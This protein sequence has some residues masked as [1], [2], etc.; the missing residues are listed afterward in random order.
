MKKFLF[1]AVAVA[2]MA[3]CSSN[4]DLSEGQGQSGGKET[5]G[6]QVLN[7]NSITR[8]T[9]LNESGHYNFGV[10]A[11]K[12][13][14]G[15]NSVMDNYLV[16]YMDEVNKKGYYMDGNQTTKGDSEGDYNG[17]SMWQYEML[18]YAEYNYLGTEGYYTKDQTAY[19]SNKEN[20]YL[21]YWDLAAPTT[22]FYAYSPY[23]NSRVTA[24]AT[25]DNSSHVLTIPNGSI[26]A[27]YVEGNESTELCEYM[28]AATQVGKADYGKDVA[29]DFKRLNAKVNIK[30][31]EDIKGYTVRILNLTNDY[32][33]SAAPAV[34]DDNDNNYTKDGAE[35]VDNCGYTVNFADLSN[36]TVEQYGADLTNA[37]LKF[38][39]PAATEIGTTRVLAT[40]SPT[41]YYALPK[42][43]STGFTFHVS[44]ELTANETGE[45]IKVQDATVHVPAANANWV[46][47]HH[48]TYIFK[49]TKNSNGTTG[50]LDPDDIKPNSPTVDTDNALYPIVFDNCTVEDWANE[51]FDPIISEGTTTTDYS[52][53]L[54]EKSVK[55]SEE[56]TFNAYLY[57]GDNQQPAPQGTWEIEEDQTSIAEAKKVTVDTQGLVTVPANAK[58]G[59]YTVKYTLADTE[60]H[61]YQN[62]SDYY[63]AQFYVVGNYAIT[64]STTEIGTGGKQ[65]TTLTTSSTLAGEPETGKAGTF[66]LQYPAGLTGDQIGQV[67]IDTNGKVTV[68]TAAKPGT[69]KVVYT[70]DEGDAIKDFEVKDF[71]FT[72]SETIVNLSQENQ[73]VDVNSA[74]DV[75]RPSTSTYGITDDAGVSINSSTGVVTVTPAAATGVYTVTRTVDCNGSTTV[76]ERTLA[77]RDI[78]TL[79]LSKYVVDNDANVTIQV[80]ATK[81]GQSNVNDV[82][83]PNATGLD[84]VKADGTIKVLSNCTPGT[85]TVKNGDKTVTFIVQ[86]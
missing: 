63:T 22:T 12:S 47:N 2:A 21:K 4:Y 29:L 86:D 68:G 78:Y 64:L 73:T 10:F 69:Y 14:D 82:E 67:T 24:T 84:C 28:Y 33:V 36:P 48:Y 1:F 65:A 23:I 32:G 80:T 39:S 75:V 74:N 55:A 46:S 66:S 59:V 79:S 42:D 16:G 57:L 51:E 19:M 60:K 15:V 38:T 13:S 77:V 18:G 40:Q 6:F 83:Y 45:R 71:G 54:A 30:F 56:K 43:N 9:S 34:L 7:R 8:A 85:Y 35:Y 31:W 5:I 62:H 81:N 37:P 11:Y 49:I 25:Y 17:H 70:T 52:V 41:T 26:K 61:K 72:L 58:T 50:D 27:A 76:Y 53:V 3:S 44:Y 20:Q